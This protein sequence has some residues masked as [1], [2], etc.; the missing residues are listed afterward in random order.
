MKDMVI[1]RIKLHFQLPYTLR[2]TSR[3]LNMTTDICRE[4][5]SRESIPD[6]F[7]TCALFFLRVV[8]NKAKGIVPNSS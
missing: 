7:F 3:L 6:E 1:F 4:S 8:L 2:D 5:I